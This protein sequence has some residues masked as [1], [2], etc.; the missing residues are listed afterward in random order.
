MDT[1]PVHCQALVLQACLRNRL[2]TVFVPALCT[3]LLQPLDTDVFAV[4]K[5]QLRQSLSCIASSAP[6]GKD[7]FEMVVMAVVVAIKK[8]LN[9]RR[10]EKA[11]DGNGFGSKKINVR[12]SPLQKLGLETIPV[13]VGDLPEWSQF[14]VILPDGYPIDF[15]L[16]LGLLEAPS[17]GAAPVTVSAHVASA[18]SSSNVPVPEMA[19]IRLTS[20]TS[21]TDNS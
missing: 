5:R 11:F 2:R 21:L 3:S 17:A 10:W 20:K 14:K 7:R 12:R 18:A 9:G 1:C 8:I 4:F 19:R 13:L 15:E 16:L 6:E